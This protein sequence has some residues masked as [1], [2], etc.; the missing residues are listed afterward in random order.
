M[1]SIRTPLPQQGT[2]LVFSLLIL[3]IMTV[4]GVAV[5]SNTQMQERM[6][7]NVNLQAIAFEAASAG[8]SQALAYG[9]ERWYDSDGERACNRQTGFWEE[10]YSAPI[11]VE[12][13][14]DA[15]QKV[16]ISYRL[17]A[18][19]LEDPGFGADPD[20]STFVPP[21]QMYI[22][23]QGIVSSG[24]Q[25]LATREI[26][27]RIDD[28]RTDGRSA[29]RIEGGTEG[30]VTID[31]DPANS[32]KFVVDGVGGP[33]ITASTL[34]NA[35]KI[36]EEIGSDRLGNYAG[37]VSKSDFGPPF[38]S[39]WKMA[40][41]ALEIRAF[42]EFHG[43][44]ASHQPADG[45]SCQGLSSSDMPQMAYTDGDISLNGSGA[46]DGITYT[47]GNLSLGGNASGS[48]LIIV[49][50]QVVWH[51]G[52]NFQGIV[53]GLGDNSGGT[54]ANKSKNFRMNG[55]GNGETS[56]M[57]YLAD[58]NIAALDEIFDALLLGWDGTDYDCW[59]G[60]AN[61]ISND[62]ALNPALNP[63]PGQPW[64]EILARMDD[65]GNPDDTGIGGTEYEPL[66]E[67]KSP[68]DSER[69]DGFGDTEVSFAGGG[70]HSVT[71]DCNDADRQRWILS[72][73]GLTSDEQMGIPV[74]NNGFKYDGLA[75]PW[76]DQLCNTPGAGGSIQAIRSWRENLGW[77]ELLTAGG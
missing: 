28:F 32:D 58:V 6:A 68:S 63:F 11:Y 13:Q 55:G 19:C 27:V 26:E 34:S 62:P 35:G 7:G 31:F 23:S 36:A 69:P 43:F 72:Q 14:G 25:Q 76:N 60:C 22:T 57:I 17:K 71:Y 9:M 37:G 45:L 12:L 24:G 40:R 39:A 41:F 33:A 38:N 15:A 52:A 61:A 48:G 59:A 54:G 21:V 29:M 66:T 5:M 18:D 64:E 67:K 42:L 53:I 30:D 20:D 73:C 75:D 65:W 4:L 77:R 56:G 70:N 10:D 3:L 16:D 49:E 46:L 47:R 2:A 74:E 8:V 51:G 1:H 50:G 44:E